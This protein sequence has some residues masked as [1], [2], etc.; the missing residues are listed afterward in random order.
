MAKKHSG[1]WQQSASEALRA[2]ADFVLI[3]RSPRETPG[4]EGDKESAEVDLVTANRTLSAL[5]ERLFAASRVDDSAASVL[6]VL[7]GMDTA[8]KGGIVRHVMGLFDPQG[9][10][11]HAFK[12]PTPAEAKHNFLWRV[13]KQLP[14]PGHIGVFDRSHYEDVLIHKV[15]HLSTAEQIEA[16]YGQIVKFERQLAERGTR[17]IKVMLHLGSEEQF[18]RLAERLQ[19]PDKY[20]KYD[21]SDVDARLAWDDYQ[22]AYEAAIER[23]STET[24]PWYI[25]P[26]DQKWRARLCVA[27]LLLH[28]LRQ[29]DPAW[30]E[31]RFDVDAERRRLA[32]AAEAGGQ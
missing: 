9:V 12:A 15:E 4:Y 23:T 31:A 29:I 2:D 20:W 13:K 6:L 26:A 14:A 18:S 22:Q 24:A 7:Q 1:S 28:T 10:A 25:V 8:G 17:I 5:Q 32:A 30:P 27:E 16:R 21:P 11:H 3:N 19:R